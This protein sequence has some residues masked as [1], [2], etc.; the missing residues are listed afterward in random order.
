[1]AETHVLPAVAQPFLD[2][3]GVPDSP[4]CAIPLHRVL[5]S[6][7]TRVETV[8]AAAGSR[9]VLVASTPFEAD[10]WVSCIRE[11]QVRRATLSA[12]RSLS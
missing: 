4:S 7:D 1:M 3:R 11:A 12:A 6:Y 2:P 10:A 5:H 9:I 8:E